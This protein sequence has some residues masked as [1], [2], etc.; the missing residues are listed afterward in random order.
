MILESS[1]ASRLLL[2]GTMAAAFACRGAEPPASAPPA[3][4][5]ATAP[6]PPERELAYVTNEVSGNLSVISTTTDRVV[7]DIPVGLRPRGVKLSPDGR[8]VYVALSG[9]PRCPP[10]MPDADCAKLKSDKSRDGIAIV[11]VAAR[12]V[13]RVLPGGSDPEQFDVSP[14]GSRLYVSNEDAGVATIVDVASGQILHTVK[15]GD[16]PEGV[17]RSPDGKIVYVTSE[18]DRQVTVLDAST[19]EVRA[20]FKVG[21][22]PRDAIFTADGKRAYVSSEL[23]GIVVEVDATRHVVTAK[24]AMPAGSRSMGLALSPDGRSLYVT[25]GRAQTVTQVDIASR[26]IVR[27]VEVGVRPWGIAATPDGSR[28]YIANGPSNDVAVVDA[29]T[30]AVKARIPVGESPWGVVVGPGPAT[31]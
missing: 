23:E 22:R 3:S 27:S 10:S 18:G 24:I 26:K 30:F 25:N 28:L 31:R 13:V 5:P 21:A 12:R 8:T 9:S 2:I 15:V 14:D 20:T 16:E 4:A 11:D 6:S 29:A 1:V 17:R 19:G 7:A